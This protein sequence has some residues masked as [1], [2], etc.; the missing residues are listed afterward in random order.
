MR[1]A[2][3]RCGARARKG[4]RLPVLFSPHAALRAH[5]HFSASIPPPPR[6]RLQVREYWLCRQ[7]AGLAVVLPSS[8][9]GCR[10]EY[11]RITACVKS[12]AGDE[13]AAEAFRSRRLAELAAARAAAVA[14]SGERR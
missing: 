14:A 10:D 11:A 12:H 7:S 13:A 4:R 1:S 5:Y 6:P 8:W 2:R 9:G 3:Q